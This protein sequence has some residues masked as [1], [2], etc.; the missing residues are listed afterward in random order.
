MREYIISDLLNESQLV[1]GVDT[2]SYPWFAV[3][4]FHNGKFCF[5]ESNYGEFGMG[6]YPMRCNTVGCD[7]YDEAFF[8]DLRPVI[9]DP[10]VFAYH[11]TSSNCGYL[12]LRHDTIWEVYCLSARS[13]LRKIVDSA[14]TREDAVSMLSERIGFE[15]WTWEN[16]SEVGTKYT[17]ENIKSLDYNQI[18]V[19]GSNLQGMHLGGAARCAVQNFNAVMGQGVGLQGESYAIP[20]MFDTVEEIRPYV[21]EFLRFAEEHR[22]LE[23]YVTKIGCNIAGFKEG[24]IAPLFLYAL[25]L[26]NVILPKSFVEIIE[27]LYR[28]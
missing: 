4:R 23:F 18:F 15:P 22:Y 28:S 3:Y 16:L 14:P 13:G 19:F 25:K 8:S 17:P 27:D 2:E 21:D 5:T 26:K 7:T 6:Y 12:A 11:M 9:Y 1:L 24:D 10:G 20:T